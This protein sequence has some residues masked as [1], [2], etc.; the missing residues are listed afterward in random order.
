MIVYPS[1]QSRIIQFEEMSLN[2]WPAIQEVHHN[3]CIVRL[4]NGYTKRANSVNALYFA[5]NIPELIKYSE[6]FYNKNSLPTVFKILKHK[7]YE[8]L[9]RLLEDQGYKVIDTTNVK[10]LDVRRNDFTNNRVVTLEN[11]FSKEWISEFVHVN[12]I[13]NK[14]G[15]VEEMLSKITVDK[16]VA[17][18]TVESKIV[19]FG[20]GAIENDMIG[21]FDIYVD[22]KYR[23]RGYA[24][25]I[26]NKI[27][28]W[29]KNK[30]IIYSYLQVVETNEIANRL[31]R[32]LGY[33]PYYKYWY[34][35]KS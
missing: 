7:K 22:E 32:S 4:S 29:A 21:I 27:L 9:D 30:N 18:I 15:T 17:S 1:N 25:K 28:Y 3:G 33:K 10:L 20:Y 12:R 8:H 26:M 6:M 13:E 24:R 16:V 34:R 31:Y 14:M 19:G 23:R 35:I 11:S 5:E 2:A